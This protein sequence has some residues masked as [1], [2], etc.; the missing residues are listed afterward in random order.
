MKKALIAVGA[1]VVA[2]SLGLASVYFAMPMLSPAT[3]ER[4]QIRLDSIAVA[5]SLARLGLVDSFGFLAEGINRPPDS[6]A[7][8]LPDSLADT[9]SVQDST[10]SA[11]EPALDETITAIEDSTAIQ[12]SLVVMQRT[13]D[14]LLKEPPEIQAGFGLYESDR[15]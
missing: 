5:D 11:D 14:V 8:L 2:F 1:V 12:D 4:V 7:V 9:G 10:R 15:R 6:L 13:L 3:A